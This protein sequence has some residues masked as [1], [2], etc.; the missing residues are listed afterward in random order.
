MASDACKS[1]A[2][3]VAKATDAFSALACGLAENEEFSALG[4]CAG[5][6]CGDVCKAA[7]LDGGLD[8]PFGDF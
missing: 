3:C 1:Q 7:P 5:Q 8:D 6:Q 2:D 4:A